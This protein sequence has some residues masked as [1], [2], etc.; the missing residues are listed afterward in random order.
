VKKS[1]KIGNTVYTVKVEADV[2]EISETTYPKPGWGNNF[3]TIYILD[4]G[5]SKRWARIYVECVNNGWACRGH[6]M[7]AVW[8]EDE[9]FLPIAE[10]RE[11]LSKIRSVLAESEDG[12]PDVKEV[13][14]R[15]AGYR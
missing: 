5:Y 6:G 3:S 14:D 9:D 13:F 15:Y 1:V 8:A 2:V 11:I 10:A 7:T 12:T 4:L